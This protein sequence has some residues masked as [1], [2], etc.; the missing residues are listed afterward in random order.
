[1]GISK[2]IN[3]DEFEILDLEYRPTWHTTKHICGIIVKWAVILSPHMMPD[4]IYEVI[5]DINK[6][7]IDIHTDCTEYQYDSYIFSSN[8]MDLRYSIKHVIYAHARSWNC[9]ENPCYID[10]DALILNVFDDITL[11]S[12]RRDL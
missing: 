7:L 6:A 3:I 1:M 12:R 2:Y 11:E 9:K 5:S 4:D 10:L 8:L